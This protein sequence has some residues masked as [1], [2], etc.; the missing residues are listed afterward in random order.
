VAGS[1]DVRAKAVTGKVE[2]S[3]AGSGGVT[4]G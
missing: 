2:K 3:V 4:I 1:G